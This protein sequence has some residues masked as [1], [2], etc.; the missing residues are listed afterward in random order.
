MMPTFQSMYTIQKMTDIEKIPDR[1]KKRP[2]W[3]TFGSEKD[4]I[5]EDKKMPSKE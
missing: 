4:F 3:P 1:D 5:L 2:E